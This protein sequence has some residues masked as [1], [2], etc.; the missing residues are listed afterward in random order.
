MKAQRIVDLFIALVAAV[1]VGMLVRQSSPLTD[2]EPMRAVIELT[3]TSGGNYDLFLDRGDGF[4]GDGSV[5]TKVHGSD[6]PQRIEFTWPQDKRNVTALR[7]DPGDTLVDVVLHSFTIEGPGGSITWN[8]GQMLNR[9]GRVHGLETLP[10][11]DDRLVLHIRRED[12]WIATSGDLSSTLASVAHGSPALSRWLIPL[13]SACVA[14]LLAFLVAIPVVRRSVRASAVPLKV[15]L[16]LLPIDVLVFTA[17]FGV[18]QRIGERATGVTFELQ[19]L[20]PSNDVYQLF[21]SRNAGRFGPEQCV[22]TPVKTSVGPQWV[23]FELPQDTFPTALRFDPGSRADSLVI[24]SAA[25]AHGDE[26]EHIAASELLNAIDGKHD[27]ATA[28]LRNGG[29]TLRFNGRDPYFSLADLFHER[30]VAVTERDK[31]LWLPLLLAAVLA[32]LAHAGLLRAHRFVQAVDAAAPRDLRLAC[33]FLLLLLLPVFTTLAPMLEVHKDSTENRRLAQLPALELRS[34]GEF[35]ARYDKWYRDHFGYRQELF[36]WNSW[37]HIKVLNTSPMADRVIVGKDGWFFQY[38][39]EVDGDYRGR[40]LYDFDQLERIRH[41]YEARQR[42]LAT[43]GIRYYVLV[44]PLSGNLNREHMPDRFRRVSD[45]T[46]LDQVKA[47]FDKYSTVELIDPR[48]DL[49]A[50]KKERE[51]YFK[52]DIHWN[53]YGAYFGYRELIERVH[54]DIPAIGAPCTLDDLALRVDTN[55]RGD[56]AGMLGLNDV[57]TRVEPF[58]VPLRPRKSVFSHFP[59]L[60]GQY[61]FLD[62]PMTFT[63]PDTT[64]PK[65]LMFHDSFGLYLKPLINE[66]FSKTTYVW[67][68]L[69]IPDVVVAEKPDVV[70]Q[71]FMEMFIVNMPKDSL[72]VSW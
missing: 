71:E 36:R 25:F 29:M 44:P 41:I 72:A 61:Y 38:N 62:R 9:F 51:V 42:W 14:F 39:A 1:A 37:T 64:L 30:M 31:P 55:E 19:A 40:T 66:H 21:Y 16:V 27:I 6:R 28:Q 52:T 24:Y 11:S 32:L 56:L 34:L 18:G 48:A 13:L 35:P 63:Q 15:L 8:A 12:P 26:R 20:I 50:A 46:W 4:R 59:E 49:L 70:V 5:R 58:V 69:F 43:F 33:A 47:H 10:L 45:S 23:R 22:A 67:A 3:S 17:T 2:P 53:P 54:R 65:L 57:L 60:P 7:F 68:G